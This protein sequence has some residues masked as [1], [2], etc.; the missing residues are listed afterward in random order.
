MLE[1]KVLK[2]RLATG[3]CCLASNS[4]RLLWKLVLGA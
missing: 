2:Y 3:M 4:E 1:P